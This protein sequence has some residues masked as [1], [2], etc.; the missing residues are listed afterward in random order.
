MSRIVLFHLVCLTWIFFRADSIRDSVAFLSGIGNLQL[1]SHFVAA[2]SFLAA[3]TVPLFL[4]D[5]TL[6]GRREE[7]LFER[8]AALP[9]VAAA[10]VL[11]LI[12]A[13]FSANSS[14]AFIY[15][16]F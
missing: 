14:A 10:A 12:L 3:F 6:E 2:M 4:L 16:Q 11:V 9:R 5:L 1:G 8:L 13:L 15:F 7:Y